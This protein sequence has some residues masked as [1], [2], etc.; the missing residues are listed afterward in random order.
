LP[1][2]KLLWQGHQC[3]RKAVALTFLK[4]P[5]VLIQRILPKRVGEQ[6]FCSLFFLVVIPLLTLGLILLYTSQKAITATVWLN[7]EEIAVHATGEIKEHVHGVQQWLFITAM[8]LGNF[9]AN[10]KLQ[11]AA[12]VDLSLKD[13]AFQRITSINMRGREI[14]STGLRDPLRNYSDNE[15]FLEA[16]SGQSYSSPVE[17]S[18]SNIPFFIMAEPIRQAGRVKGVLLA[19]K[20]LKNI[21]TIVDNIHI[22]KKGMAYLIDQKGRIIAHPDKTLVLKNISISYPGIIENIAAG[23]TGNLE[24]TK[25]GEKRLISYAPIKDLHWGLIISQPEQEALVNLNL[26]KIQSIIVLG[27]SIAGALLVSFFLAQYMSRPMKILIEGTQRIAQGNFSHFYQIRSRSEI[28]RLF[29]SFNRM[30]RKL[31]QAKEM[32]S[33]SMIGKAATVIAH[34]LK[35]SLQLIDTFVRVLPER[36]QDKRFIKEFS[37]AIPKELDSWN[38]LLKNMMTYAGHSQID[39]REFDI[40]GIIRDVALLMNLKMRQMGIYF[41]VELQNDL[42]LIRGDREMLKHVFLNL[43]TN[44][45]EWTSLSKEI[46]ISTREEPGLRPTNDRHIEVEVTNTGGE[47]SE[48]VRKRMFEPFYT[49]KSGGLGLGLSISKQII[50]EHGGAIRALNQ[51]GR[52]SFIIT[53][54]AIVSDKKL[55]ETRFSKDW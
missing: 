7:H 49:T 3:L 38:I 11:K 26:M 25:D 19:E 54:P 9:K 32:E 5:S 29:F 45:M 16:S 35:N 24:E 33:L 15:A 10:P 50:D 55:P 8:M 20:N 40:N 53:L 37:E 36:H 34:E 21:W 14:A 48:E 18:E 51:N 30:M 6:I 42:P 39:L 12:L 46:V 43:L 27:L 52:T 23:R 31:R 4:F 17:I 28:D 41:K 1:A 44:A 2:L 13:P 47:I 22:G